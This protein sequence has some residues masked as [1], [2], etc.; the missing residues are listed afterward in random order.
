MMWSRLLVVT[1]FLAVFCTAVPS[2]GPAFIYHEPDDLIAMTV[3]CDQ[4][5][6]VGDETWRA[7]GKAIVEFY[8]GPT[9]VLHRVDATQKYANDLFW[10]I[11][12]TCRDEFDIF[13]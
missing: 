3:N 2:A 8:E 5:E 11:E 6:R 10:T 13:D 7:E 1:F 12:G 4:W 9:L